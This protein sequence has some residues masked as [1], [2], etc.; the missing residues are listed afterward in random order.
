MSDDRLAEELERY[1]RAGADSTTLKAL[2]PRIKEYL[3]RRGP[4]TREQCEAYLCELLGVQPEGL[5]VLE[6]WG[7]VFVLMFEREPTQLD[8]DD[9]TRKVKDR[10]P[11]FVSLR[12]VHCPRDLAEAAETSYRLGDIPA[13]KALLGV[14]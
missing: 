4:L 1:A 11:A 3:E 13:V 7:E 9:V 14:A 5:M 8:I 2:M 10:L 12:L 6:G